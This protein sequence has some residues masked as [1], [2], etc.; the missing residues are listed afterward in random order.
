[1]VFWFHAPDDTRPALFRLL[2]QNKYPASQL[3]LLMT[4]GPTLTVIALTERAR[5]W[6]GRMLMTFGRVPLFYYLL[7][8]PLIHVTALAVYF[9]R[10]VSVQT[11]W[12]ASA[13]SVAVPR[14]HSWGL[15][16]LYVVF[17]IDV[18]ILYVACRWY[19]QVKA[20][21]PKGWLRYL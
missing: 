9:L 17:V 1:M 3:F 13:P 14:E 19:A 8:I 10:D 5:G 4:L 20:R 12:F 11:S 16:L 2:A 21:H 7:H 6:F 15:G 18:A